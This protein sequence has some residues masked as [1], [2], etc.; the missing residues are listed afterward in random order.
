[1]IAV[2]PSLQ[3]LRYMANV[4]VKQDGVIKVTVNVAAEVIKDVYGGVRRYENEWIPQTG[5]ADSS[6]NAGGRRKLNTNTGH[7][8]GCLFAGKQFI[9]VRIDF[10][11]CP[12]I[13]KSLTAAS[14]DVLHSCY[15]LVGILIRFLNHNLYRTFV[16]F[17]DLTI[18]PVTV[19]KVFAINLIRGGRELMKLMQCSQCG[20]IQFLEMN[21]IRIASTDEELLE[22]GLSVA[23]GS[24]GYEELL[25][26]VT[27]HRS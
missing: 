16:G 6:A 19:I 20:S 7:A 22:T 18:I 23:D 8:F 12:G 1:M 9:K 10:V 14:E 11:I 13:S 27:D 2:A 4:I 3:D 26:W 24:M 25:R 21:G 5:N 15:A 17:C